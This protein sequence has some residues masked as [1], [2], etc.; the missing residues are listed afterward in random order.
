LQRGVRKTFPAAKAGFLLQRLRRDQGRAL[1]QKPRSQGFSAS[2][3]SV[4]FQDSSDAACLLRMTI[5]FPR[6]VFS[7]S[8]LVHSAYAAWAWPGIA[9]GIKMVMVVPLRL[10]S[11]LLVTEI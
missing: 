4:L 1:I 10:G 5:Q 9:K 2:T 7:Q 8:R 11:T 6:G 3:E